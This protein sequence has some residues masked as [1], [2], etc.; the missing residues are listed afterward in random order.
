MSLIALADLTGKLKRDASYDCK[1]DR[2]REPNI[3][4]IL[5]STKCLGPGR[6]QVGRTLNSANSRH[7]TVIRLNKATLGTFPD[8]N[9]K[10]SCPM[11]DLRLERL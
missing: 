11:D 8:R 5:F 6:L 2:E 4:R 10:L 7:D 3:E 1:N 9:V